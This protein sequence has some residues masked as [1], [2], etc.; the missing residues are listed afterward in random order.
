MTVGKKYKA[1]L[2]DMDG[3]LIDSERVYTVS[4]SEA[5]IKLGIKQGLTW[6]LKAKLQGLPGVEAC[7][8]TIDFH[9]L[10]DKITAEELFKITSERQLE[11]WP[12]VNLL[13]GVSKLIN[14]LHE[15]KVPIC[16]CTSSDKAKYE[17]KTQNSHSVFKLFDGNIIT[18][19]NETIKGKGFR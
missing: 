4:F 3:L 6:D 5:L 15:H 10:Q 7:Q 9:H 17:L 16:V 8:V 1:C 2:F 14:Y 12:Q 19:D 11:L 13:P 18:A